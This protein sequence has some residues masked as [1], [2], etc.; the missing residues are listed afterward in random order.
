LR[1]F[2]GIQKALAPKAGNFCK[3]G[4]ANLPA[5]L[6]QL[7]ST[8]PEREIRKSGLYWYFGFFVVS[9]FCGLVYEVV[10]AR[11]AMASFGV[12][13]ALTSIVIS[14][15]MAGLGLGSWGTGLLTRRILSVDGPRALRL[16]SLAELLVGISSLAVP[17]QFKLGRQLL[18]HMGSFGA[19][20]SSSYYILVGIWIGITLVPWCTC[21]GSTFPL[22]MAVIRQT[23]RPK[24]EHSFSYLYV[25][26][27]LGALLGTLASAF[28]LIELL[29]FQRC[30]GNAECN[31]G[32]ISLRSE[33][34]SWFGYTN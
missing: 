17:L 7:D 22:L 2:D 21:M 6:D 25:A 18:L 31:F 30:C 3:Q 24:S 16:Y 33:S 14:M 34:A 23:A 32:T 5:E 8:V 1:A 19:W 4:E 29:G 28:V 12:T 20:Q 27:V 15:F 13:T 11:L 9:G 26:N 10:W